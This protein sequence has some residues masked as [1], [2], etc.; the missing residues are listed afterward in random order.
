MNQINFDD[1]SLPELKQMARSVDLD[2]SSKSRDAIVKE[3]KSIFKIVEDR[4]TKFTECGSLGYKGKEGTVYEVR[5]K[6]G[7]IYAMKRFRSGKSASRLEHEAQLLGVAS[8]SGIA[9]RLVDYSRSGGW[10]VMEKL[11]KNVFDILKSTNGILSKTVQL[12]MIDIFRKLDEIRIFH[13]DPNP[14]N[15]MLDEKGRLYIIDFGFAK[16]FEEPSVQ[17][18]STATPNMQ[19]MPLGFL[20]KIA[21]NCDVRNFTVLLKHVSPEGRKQL[22]IA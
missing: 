1:F 8:A 15:F 2:P 13:A 12:Q 4:R 21:G 11:H 18:L 5:D 3:L 19:F 6:S 20:M 16:T 10:I 7:A 17:Q 22:G 9:P 14:L